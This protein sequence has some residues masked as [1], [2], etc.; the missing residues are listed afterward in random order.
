MGHCTNS[1]EQQLQFKV[2]RT[3]SSDAEKNVDFAKRLRVSIRKYMHINFEKVDF[4]KTG[5]RINL[6]RKYEN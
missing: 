3:E 6:K 2:I 1:G 5:Q 4:Q